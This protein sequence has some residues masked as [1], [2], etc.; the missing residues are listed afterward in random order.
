MFDLTFYCI[1]PHPHI[2]N[3][4]VGFGYGAIGERVIPWRTIAVDPRVIAYGTEVYI[5]GYGTFRANDTG[6][7][8]TGNRIDIAVETHAEALRLGI[9]TAEVFVRNPG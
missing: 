8:I 2:C 5:K 4:G 1:E 7:A 6:G 3:N 9:D